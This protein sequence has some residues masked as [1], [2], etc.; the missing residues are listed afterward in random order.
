[1]SYNI[2]DTYVHIYSTTNRILI[3]PTQEKLQAKHH[4]IE[5]EEL[6]AAA[7]TNTTS[8]SD[9]DIPDRSLPV[10]IQ[11]ILPYI[12]SFKSP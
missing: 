4:R 2:R 3:D 11:L 12:I 10:D 6:A 1:M 9:P 5:V 7:A 8:A